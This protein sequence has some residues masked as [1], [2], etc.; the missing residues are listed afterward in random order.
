MRILF[1]IFLMLLTTKTT[2]EEDT[3]FNNI[4]QLNI[5]EEADR[6]RDLVS[7]ELPQNISQNLVL[8]SITSFKNTLTSNAM[9]LYDRDFLE[10]AL[11]DG[12]R[13][14]DSIKQQMEV[15]TQNVACSMSYSKAFIELGGIKNY[16]Y[17][18]QDGELF[19][20]I[21]IKECE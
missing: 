21:S 1:I 6:V 13:T 12:G 10:T 8:R 14:M 18:F 15:M 7:N 20:E 16:V 5:C 17:Q 9:L 4:I 19:Q 3:C 2:A 11:S